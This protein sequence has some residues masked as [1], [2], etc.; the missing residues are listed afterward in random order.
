MFQQKY[1]AENSL[2]FAF[3]YCLYEIAELA[4]MLTLRTIITDKKW[5]YV[6]SK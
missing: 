1:E 5:A 2:I 3:Y 4:G 6:V